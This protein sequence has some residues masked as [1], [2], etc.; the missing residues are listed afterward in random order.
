MRPPQAGKQLQMMVT[1]LRP[2]RVAG[3]LSRHSG[4]SAAQQVGALHTGLCWA[5]GGAAVGMLV[6]YTDLPPQQSCRD[7]RQT[8]QAQRFS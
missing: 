4:L 7:G 1:G 6:A 3:R 2:A 8:R 5:F